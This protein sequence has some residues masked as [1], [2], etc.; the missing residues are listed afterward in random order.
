MTYKH[1]TT[2]D[3]DSEKWIKNILR[4]KNKKANKFKGSPLQKKAINFDKK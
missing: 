1:E 2:P 4:S 3:K